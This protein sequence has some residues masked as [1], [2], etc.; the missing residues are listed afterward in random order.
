MT[1]T[2]LFVPVFAPQ[3]C[4]HLSAVCVSVLVIKN[5]F[6]KF[7]AA[8]VKENCI[9]SFKIKNAKFQLHIDAGHYDA[10][11]KHLNVVL[12]INS[13]AKSSALKD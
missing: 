2:V 6:V 8:V 13:Q 7:T 10:S 12:Q 9:L 1:S 4:S 5:A 11:I 3:C